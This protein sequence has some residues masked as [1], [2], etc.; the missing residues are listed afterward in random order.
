[1]N[2]VADKTGDIK[3]LSIDEL[4]RILW[5]FHHLDSD[6]R[7]EQGTVAADCLIVCGS[8]EERVA[9]R[10]AN[11]YRQGNINKIVFSGSKV[12]E[13]FE[14]KY[15]EGLSEA[16][17]FAKIAIGQGV[18][19]EAIL[20]ENKAT[21]TPQNMDFSAELLSEHNIPYDNI[22]I[23]SAAQ[24][25][26]RSLATARQKI[27]GKEIRVT[28][29][30]ESFESFINDP[31]Y[32]KGRI[33]ALV[34]H[35]LRLYVFGRKGDLV[36]QDIPANVLEAYRELIHRGFPPLAVESL[37]KDLDELNIDYTKL[38]AGDETSPR[39]GHLTVR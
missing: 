5:D 35:T 7:N 37:Q 17:V 23:V 14:K 24:H 19:K 26:R 33:Q 3:Q 39:E 18:P 15:G 34:G 30:E 20:I 31:N 25:E 10:A 6:L 11:L 1:M 28:S 13:R 4:A 21:N 36:E 8:N 16:E 32:R 9:L 2:T 12:H 22:I 38:E 27:P 29:P